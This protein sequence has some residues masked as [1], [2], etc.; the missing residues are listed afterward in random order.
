M[1][2]NINDIVEYYEKL[3]IIQ[4]YDKPKA[5]AEIGLLARTLLA[6]GLIFD[7]EDAFDLETAVGNQL[8]ILGKYIGADRFYK[9]QVFIGSGF[10]ENIDYAEIPYTPS[11]DEKGFSDYSNF[12]T[13]VGKFLNYESFVT[14]GLKL[15]DINYRFI[16]KLK[17]V[18]NNINHSDQAIDEGL[19]SFFEDDLYAID[20]LDMTMTYFVA[21]SNIEI[22]KIALQKEVL[23][24]PIGVG[25]N[26]LV[27]RNEEIF[28]FTD[29]EETTI[30]SLITGFSDYSDYDTK[31]GESLT[32]EKLVAV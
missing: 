9:G 28:A 6:D 19:Y 21:T 30:S 10:F 27:E 20:N 1:A 12:D 24:K 13:I 7:L 23:P 2:T 15:D 29:Y 18:Q 16:L 11:G 22:V 5:K 17:R 8:D 14:E 25:I 31:V 3:L 32:Y 26:C 4:Y